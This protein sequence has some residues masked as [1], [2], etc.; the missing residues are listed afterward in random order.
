M[1]KDY[2]KWTP[3]KKEIND[4]NLR[5]LWYKERDIWICNLGENIGFEEDGKGNDFTRPV[6]ILKVFNKY[7]CYVVSL[8]TTK[9]RGKYFYSFDGRTGKISVVLLSHSKSIDSL[10]LRKKIGFVSKEDF[11]KIIE[12]LFHILKNKV[13]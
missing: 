3:V 11:N 9:K 12:N 8:S 1:Y 10:R 2:K 7:F 13:P 6:L 5:P 4:L